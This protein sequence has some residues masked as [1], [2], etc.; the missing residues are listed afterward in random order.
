MGAGVVTGLVIG[1]GGLTE[2][3]IGGTTTGVMEGIGIGV[4][5]GF[6]GVIVTGL[7][8]GTVTIVGVGLSCGTVPGGLIV[9]CEVV[10]KSSR[11][12]EGKI[13]S[14]SLSSSFQLKVRT[15]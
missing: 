2:G 11:R 9:S 12:D 14:C 8:A 4:D 13:C 6:V 5:A 10:F 3:F 7:V 1:A 15:R